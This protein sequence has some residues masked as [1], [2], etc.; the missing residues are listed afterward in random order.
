MYVHIVRIQSRIERTN[1]FISASLENARS[2]TAN[3]P[4]TIRFDVLRDES[5]PNIIYLYEVY[6]D[7]A[8]YDNHRTMPHYQ[9]WRDTVKDWFAAPIEIIATS[10]LFPKDDLWKKEPV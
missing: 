2:T 7:R 8:A 6:L 4:R 1:D 3:E 9:K 10:S 5:N